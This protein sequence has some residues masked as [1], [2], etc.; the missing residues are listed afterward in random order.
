MTADVKYYHCCC[1]QGPRCAKED[2]CCLHCPLQPE[3][4]HNPVY[5]P[6][7][8]VI[9]LG[10]HTWLAGAGSPGGLPC[11]GLGGLCLARAQQVLLLRGVVLKQ[12]ALVRQ[13]G[14][15]LAPLLPCHTGP[16]ALHEP[17]LCGRARVSCHECIVQHK[18]RAL[19]HAVRAVQQWLQRSCWAACSR[20]GAGSCQSRCVIRVQAAACMAGIC[21]AHT[22]RPPAELDDSPA[23]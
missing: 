20:I 18:Q 14:R 23:S 12:V 11:R 16:L 3:Q 15:Q 2:G 5:D 13:R 19:G 1:P 22:S 7:G 17:H 21:W 9:Q 10:S 8:A 4:K 6:L